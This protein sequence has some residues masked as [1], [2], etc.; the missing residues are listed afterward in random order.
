[1]VL[2]RLGPSLWDRWS[3][4]GQ[5]MP[6]QLVACVAVEA[7]AILRALHARGWVHGDVKPENFL[8]GAPGTATAD[9]LFLVDFG[10]AQRWRDAKSGAHARYDQR[11]DDFRGTIRYA[12][13][14]AHMGR[15]PARRDDLESL[16]YTL[17]F[18]LAGRL[19]WQGYQGEHKGYAVARKKMSTS[20]EALA[21]HRPP[22]FR[23]FAEAV[24]ALRFDEEPPYA[25][26]AELFAPLCGPA[27]ARPLQID[28][29]LA[30]AAAAAAAAGRKRARDDGAEGAEGAEGADA[31]PPGLLAELASGARKKARLGFPAAQWVSVFS[32][33]LPMKQR[34]HYNVSSARLA[35]HLAKGYDDGLRVSCACACADLWAVVMDA[36]TGYSAQVYHTAAKA[37]LPKDWVTEHWDRGYYITA[38]AGSASGGALVVMSK[39]TRFTQQSYKVS[40]GWLVGL[41]VVVVVVVVVGV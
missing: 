24:A 35:L 18:L 27:G 17:L 20:A 26:L 33:R 39:G 41:R 36:G 30:A 29:A 6:A 14:H 32:R 9:R 7:L 5:A 22:P 16:A 37:F 15:T 4:G 21:R 25:E 38:V 23:A 10:L 1:M 34:Y 13:V 40:V 12:S 8:L 3:S 2:D 19:P 28:G 31:A 11:P